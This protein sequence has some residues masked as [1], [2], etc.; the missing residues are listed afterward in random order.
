[1]HKVSRISSYIFTNITCPASVFLRYYRIEHRR[2]RRR[3]EDR[4]SFLFFFK[5]RPFLTLSYLRFRAGAKTVL[6]VAPSDIGSGGCCEMTRLSKA[7][8]RRWC[9]M[10]LV[11]QNIVKISRIA[12]PSPVIYFVGITF[13]VL[14]MKSQN[15]RDYIFSMCNNIYTLVSWIFIGI[16]WITWWSGLYDYLCKHPLTYLFRINLVF[17]YSLFAIVILYCDSIALQKFG[18]SL[19]GI[20]I[21]INVRRNANSKITVIIVLLLVYIRNRSFV[22]WRTKFTIDV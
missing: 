2:C 19:K 17:L 22:L 3:L 15:G 10:F 16:V 7:R 6:I 1:M 18:D 21:Y 20:S 11:S 5:F 14:R 12:M 8:E 4:F 9:F 13:L